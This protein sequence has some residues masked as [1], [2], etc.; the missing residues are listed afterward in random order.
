MY[1]FFCFFLF[2]YVLIKQTIRIKSRLLEGITDFEND[3]KVLTEAKDKNKDIEKLK[4][5]IKDY[6]EELKGK[7]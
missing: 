3:I 5:E 4:K 7:N 2:H 6:T 1:R